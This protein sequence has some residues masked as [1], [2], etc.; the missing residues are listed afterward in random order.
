[1]FQAVAD[2]SPPVTVL[3]FAVDDCEVYLRNGETRP[4]ERRCISRSTLLQG[5]LENAE[6]GEEAQVPLD[7]DAMLL[8]MSQVPVLYS[9]VLLGRGS[10]G[11]CRIC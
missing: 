10:L 7:E 5:L 2:S 4:C 11:G 3:R 1:M 6:V 9:C 8:W